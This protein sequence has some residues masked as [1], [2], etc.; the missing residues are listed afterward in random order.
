MR[1]IV[2][3]DT[4]PEFNADS[5]AL[6]KVVASRLGLLPRKRGSTDVMH[7]LLLELYE[8]QKVATREKV[9]EKAVM[10]VEEMAGFSGITKQT[11]Y[12]YLERWLVIEFIHKVTFLSN[13]KKVIGYKIN[14]TTLEDAFKKTQ[15]VV[16]NNLRETETYISELQKLLKN[17]KIRASMKNKE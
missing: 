3:Q 14:G 2:L 12:E 10:S 9:P 7:K 13:G 5:D 17:E 4:E 8:R 15:V 11:M 6:A 1:K 16:V